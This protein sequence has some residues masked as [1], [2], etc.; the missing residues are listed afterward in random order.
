MVVWWC[1][2]L[3]EVPVRENILI[4][5][6]L[7]R[8]RKKKFSRD[9]YY[10]YSKSVCFRPGPGSLSRNS[11]LCDPLYPCYLY[12]PQPLSGLA[13]LLLVLRPPPPPLS[14]DPGD[15]LPTNTNVSLIAPENDP[16][17]G[18]LGLRDALSTPRPR[19]REGLCVSGR[20]S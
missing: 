10:A 3:H 20:A 9:V 6:I 2:S 7:E 18:L 11:W 19:S 5:T 8:H 14:S 17:T 16:P 12:Q 4:F 1:G 15:P 13:S